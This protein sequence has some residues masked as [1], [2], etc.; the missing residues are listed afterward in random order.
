MTFPESVSQHNKDELRQLIVNGSKNYPGANYVEDTATDTKYD[1]SRMDAHRRTVLADKLLNG[2]K[3]VIVGRHLKNGDM[4]LVN[5]QVECIYLF[6]SSC[7]ICL[8]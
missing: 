7:Y 2:E 6:L 4:L 3:I 1:L 5:R 8:Y